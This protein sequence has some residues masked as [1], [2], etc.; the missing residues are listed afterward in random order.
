MAMKPRFK[1]S[2]Q[3]T[4]RANKSAMDYY[5]AMSGKPTPD[6]ATREV[7]AKVTRGP[8]KPGAEP[9]EHDEQSALVSWWFHYSKTL[10]FDYRLLVAVPNG[11]V[12]IR[13]A[14]N[15]HALMTYLIKEGMRKGALDLVL[16][17][18]NQNFHGL[19]IE[20]KRKT[21]GA[22]S[23]DQEFMS[24]L[25]SSQGYKCVTC[26]GFDMAKDCITRYL[27]NDC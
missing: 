27:K 10:G 24:E 1:P 2:L 14:N 3:D 4:L 15:P 5:A 26:Y 6:G 22:L 25:I 7:K 17:I 11:Q 13:F 23:S 16:F 9:L 19:L 18:A 21:K 8:R 20:M 12:M